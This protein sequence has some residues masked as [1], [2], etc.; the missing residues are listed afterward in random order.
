MSE[1]LD[2][3]IEDMQ[4]AAAQWRDTMNEMRLRR[5]QS[6]L[7]KSGITPAFELVPVTT[8]RYGVM[9]IGRWGGWL[10]QIVPMGFNER[11]VLTPESLQQVYDHGWCYDAGGLAFIALI[12]WDPAKDAEPAGYKKRATPRPRRAGETAEDTSIGAEA[13]ERLFGTIAGL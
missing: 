3:E 5:Y 9:T 10:L 4:L 8:D 12:G 13:A 6:I 11:I 7:A 2:G 1:G